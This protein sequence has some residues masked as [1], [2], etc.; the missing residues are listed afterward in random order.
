MPF[1]NAAS[2][3]QVKDTNDRHNRAS[4]H[5]NHPSSSLPQQHS[6][7]PI[8]AIHG[9]IPE[10]I[11]GRVI[12]ELTKLDGQALSLT[13][14]GGV[15]KQ[16][17]ARI[18]KLRPNGLAAKSDLL[19]VGDII[20][21]INNIQTAR[22]KHHEIVSCLKGTGDTVFLEIEYEL[23]PTTLGASNTPGIRQKTTQ[24]Q[25]SRD[26]LSFGFTVRGGHD[27]ANGGKSRPLVITHVRQGSPCDKSGIIKPGDR[28]LAI[29]NIVV[30]HHVSLDE[31]LT[32]IMNGGDMAT[33]TIEYDCSI[34]EAVEQANG[35]LMVEV[36]KAPGLDL[37][38]NLAANF[39]HNEHRH[40]IFIES[41]TA[42]TI[43][44][45]C[46]AL[47]AGDEILSIDGQKTAH[48]SLPEVQRL[49]H[50]IS[51]RIR[52][53]IM[54]VRTHRL[55]IEAPRQHMIGGSMHLHTPHHTPAMY[56]NQ[57]QQHL[58]SHR[59]LYQ[60]APHHQAMRSERAEVELISDG[61]G[62]GF[63]LQGSIFSTELLDSPPTIAEIE[64]NS[65]ADVSGRLQ[66]G[67]RLVAINGVMTEEQTLDDVNSILNES[68]LLGRVMLEIEY[69]VAESI[70][71]SSGVFQVKLAKTVNIDDIGI[72]VVDNNKEDEHGVVI[73]KIKPA[74]IAC[75]AG[76]L[77]EG[78]VILA[79]DG[80]S[81]HSRKQAYEML[82]RC[83]DYVRLKIRKIDQELEDE[84]D[85]E[86]DWITFTVE[87]K[88]RHGQA[89]GFTISG[90][91]DPLDV[92]T[93]S[94]IAKGGL[95]DRTGTLRK[96]DEIQAINGVSLRTRPLSEAIHLLQTSN[97]AVVL[98]IRRNTNDSTTNSTKSRKTPPPSV[99]S[100]A[101]A[102]NK[103]KN[104]DIDSALESWDGTENG[105]S[106]SNG[107]SK[108]GLAN[109]TRISNSS[110]AMGRSISSSR[111]QEGNLPVSG[112]KNN[113]KQQQTANASI[114][115]A[116][117]R[118]PVATS[119]PYHGNN[120]YNNS[121]KRSSQQKQPHDAAS[122]TEEN[123]VQ[124]Q[125]EVVLFRESNEDFGFS[126]S[127]G[128]TDNGVYVNSIRS[129]GPA[130]QAGMNP[131]DRIIQVN[132]EPVADLDCQSVLP[133]LASSGN[134][135]NLI[136]S[137]AITVA[138][139]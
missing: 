10:E 100:K 95:A 32:R 133:L 103:T 55:A 120:R 70:V 73:I 21:A 27:H 121:S 80:V 9:D 14:A 41:V 125:L 94:N 39:M 18:T 102:T 63:V 99:P 5:Q 3:F 69:D 42:A 15:D 19:Q 28:L 12:V 84:E 88:R 109:N 50:S 91:E 105:S 87:L 78:D 129:K 137:R 116:R 136:V 54:P 124:Q 139:N 122:I 64:R 126:I 74:S 17:P 57:P 45:R 59:H 40:A 43:A 111:A 8:Q 67:D 23:P 90:T 117:G 35:P 112:V 46:G 92:I 11:K 81:I 6:L 34:V 65:I 132:N 130:H 44:D 49:L 24:V 98:K 127:D 104:P 36:V 13:V 37:G 52:I 118:K 93:V 16:Q 25:V 107:N 113:S 115:S 134:Q 29:D 85:N 66:P 20:G 119:T 76:T 60:Q 58:L 75:R 61:P 7:V 138:S 47:H 56:R 123:T 33:F 97:E 30:D 135:L 114:A 31:A 62:F 89:L 22:L 79:I 53:E 101:T 72:Q 96:N 82:A 1:K 128:L 68:V 26:E 51:D 131:F 48:L 110:L 83:E 86:S 106:G 77:N 2:C 38:I 71:P 4:G 108:R